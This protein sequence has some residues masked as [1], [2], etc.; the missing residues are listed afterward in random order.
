MPKGKQDHIQCFLVWS[1]II[2]KLEDFM[3]EYLKSVD[4]IL[5]EQNIDITKGLS[6]DEVRERLEKFGENKLK[7]GKKKSMIKMF[8]EQLNDW[9]IYILLGATVLTIIV[10]E[11]ADAIIILAVVLINAI[12]G[13]VQEEKASKAVEALKKLSTPK[14]LVRRN[15]VLEEIDSQIGRAHV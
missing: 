2:V 10:G 15:G 13:V 9:L 12:I 4:D 6:D 3:Q 14:V 8:L 11:Y 7:E 5:S 1:F